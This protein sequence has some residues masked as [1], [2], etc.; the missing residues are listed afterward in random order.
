MGL[1]RGELLRGIGVLIRGRRESLG[2]SQDALAHNLD[3]SRNTIGNIENGRHGPSLVTLFEIAEALQIEAQFLLPRIGGASL[4]ENK[5]KMHGLE[6]E[7]ASSLASIIGER[8]EH[9]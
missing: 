8:R 7:T 4:L 5:L 1:T 6:A 3:L 9:D 2:L